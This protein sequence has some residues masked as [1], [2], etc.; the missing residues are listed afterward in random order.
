MGK[1]LSLLTAGAGEAGFVRVGAGDWIS[2]DE[3]GAVWV[4]GPAEPHAEV[5]VEDDVDHQDFI[6]MHTVLVWLSLDQENWKACSTGGGSY[7]CFQSLV[8]CG[9]HI[10]FL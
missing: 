3:A 1:D 7:S 8:L 10:L 6:S 2:G 9:S 5:E 4:E